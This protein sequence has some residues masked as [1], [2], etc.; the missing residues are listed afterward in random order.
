MMQLDQPVQ[1]SLVVVAVVLFLKLE[2]PAT[3]SSVSPWHEL[4]GKN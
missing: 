2:F 1:V 3:M 4:P